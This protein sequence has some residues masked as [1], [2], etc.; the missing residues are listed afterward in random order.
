[1]I[2]ILKNI[3][4]NLKIKQHVISKIIKCNQ[5]NFSKIE[6]GAII[7]KKIKDIEKIYGNYLI[8]ELEKQIQIKNNE[9]KQYQKFI[10]DIVEN[11]I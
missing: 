10:S 11:L 1:M 8:N 5:G 6:D 9:I 7:P 3:R 2:H 4:K